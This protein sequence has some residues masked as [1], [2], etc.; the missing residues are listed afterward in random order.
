VLCRVRPPG[1]L[2]NLKLIGF[3]NFAGAHPKAFNGTEHSCPFRYSDSVIEPRFLTEIRDGYFSQ[4]MYL[5]LLFTKISQADIF[6]TVDILNKADS[7]D[8]DARISEMHDVID[9]ID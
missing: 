7:R 9:W 4:A 5:P 6:E 2:I 8:L 3:F 1:L